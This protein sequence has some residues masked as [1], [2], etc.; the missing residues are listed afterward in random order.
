VWEGGG[1]SIVVLELG[2]GG[3]QRVRER[4]RVELSHFP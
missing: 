3:S 4:E 1:G 2:P